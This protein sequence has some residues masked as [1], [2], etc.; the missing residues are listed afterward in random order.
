MFIHKIYRVKT[1]TIIY[2]DKNKNPLS[3]AS[4]SESYMSNDLATGGDV[5]NE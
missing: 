2:H 5:A 4:F 3:M 1:A